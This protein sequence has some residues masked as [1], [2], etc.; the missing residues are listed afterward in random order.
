M[1]VMCVLDNIYVMYTNTLYKSHNHIFVHFD[2]KNGE[3]NK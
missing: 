1:I 2:M 3:I